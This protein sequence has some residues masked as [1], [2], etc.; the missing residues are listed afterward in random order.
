MTGL[1]RNL[2]HKVEQLLKVFP[3]VSLLGVRQSGK[4]TLA[5]M[6]KPDWHYIDLEK[7][8]DFN[9]VSQD[10]EFFLS[11]HPNQL[12]ID[13]AQ[14]LPVIFNILRG[15][16]DSD[17]SQTGRFIITGSSHPELLNHISESLAGRVA[18]VEVGTLK[19]NEV[20][21][22]PLSDF[23]Q[24]FTHKLSKENLPTK[25]P[26]LL[27]NCIH[28]VWFRGG[29]PEPV[30]AKSDYFYE[31]WMENYQTTYINRDI[32]KLFPK[33]NKVAYQRFLTILS[34]LSGTII[35]KAEVARS[36]EVSEPTIKEFLTIAEGTYLWRQLLSY[37]KNITK[38]VI[39]RPKGFIRDTGLL[40][41]LLK[42]HSLEDLYA[43]PCCGNSFEGFVI[44]ELLKSLEALTITN[45]HSYYY[46]TRNGAE[47]DLILDGPF[48]VLPIEI[49]H[50]VQINFRRLRA[51]TEFVKEHE[52]PFGLLINQ[53][54][55]PQWLSPHIY[56]LP[57]GWL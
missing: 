12:I 2:Y 50:G 41:Y 51:L 57:V 16:I 5:K 43:D 7:P 15:V 48:G 33:L 11:R 34:K 25:S 35:N 42:I 21:Q 52:L 8:S 44:E 47:I 46:R 29:Y 32:A 22:K 19:T 3:V 23:Y 24:L 45:V 26:P 38:S 14:E 49:K 39:K 17:R 36:I 56:Q 37:E 1:K 13:E 55:Q 53:S 31:Q 30:I 4:T 9:L 28:Q 6:L 20:F 27:R 18:I 10:P 40:H 54:D